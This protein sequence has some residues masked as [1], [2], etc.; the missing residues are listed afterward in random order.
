MSGRPIAVRF[1]LRLAT[2]R[3]VRYF[4]N[5]KERADIALLQEAFGLDPVEID[6]V[7][8]W[9]K[10]RRNCDGVIPAMRRQQTRAEPTSP[11]RPQV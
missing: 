11:T 2:S 1:F 6:D 8:P 4:W 5:W 3:V 7:I 9:G 10:P